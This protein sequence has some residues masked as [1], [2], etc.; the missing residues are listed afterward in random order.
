VDEPRLQGSLPALVTP[1]TEERDIDE[2]GVDA[3]VRRALSDGASGVL[4]AGSTGEGALLE[5]EQRARLTR[6]ARASIDGG[7]AP[8]RLVAGA[9]GLTVRALHDDVER[10]A[11]A[12]CDLVLVLAPHTYR[13]TPA[14]LA[15]L[16]REVADR[17]EKPT[18]IYHIPQ[19]TGS[20]L[21]PEVLADLADHPNIVGMKDSSPD[22]ERRA[23]FVEAT[24]DVGDFALVTGHAPT[25]AAACVDGVDGSITAIA[26]VRQRQVV[27]LHVAVAEGDA[28]RADELQAGLTRVTTALGAG[29]ASVP[30][31]LKAALQLDGV[32]AERW[33]R[34]PL[35]SVEPRRLDAVRTAL[36]R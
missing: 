14:E 33:C 36:L 19:L 12:G 4:M 9:A 18:L 35:R 2:A 32:I 16:H 29:Q 23:A 17:A 6:L 10:L 20:S 27:A 13:L 30:A 28:P 21:T 25:L 1:L 3:L 26:N 11:D 5:P 24:R 22:A 8:A 34:P 31:M 7:D 15:D